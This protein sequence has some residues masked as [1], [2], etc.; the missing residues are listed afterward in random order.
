[1]R[2]P[3]QFEPDVFTP[4]SMMADAF[5]G[6]PSLHKAPAEPRAADP[7]YQLHRHAVHHRSLRLRTID[8]LRRPGK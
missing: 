1:M 5:D 2:S 3:S 6:V 8:Q 4:P 7:S